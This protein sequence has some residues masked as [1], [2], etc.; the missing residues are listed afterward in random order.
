MA[1]L[2]EFGLS[3]GAKN[4]LDTGDIFGNITTEDAVAY[5]QTLYDFINNNGELGEELKTYF[6]NAEQNDLALPEN[7]ILAAHK[8]GEYDNTYNDIGIVYDEHP[9][10]LIVLTEE[11]WNCPKSLDCTISCS[12]MK[13]FK[14]P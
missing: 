1:K 3:I 7:N 14:I 5:M 10:L 12:A 2:R 4:T 13:P 8:Y 11:G 6:V 9:Y